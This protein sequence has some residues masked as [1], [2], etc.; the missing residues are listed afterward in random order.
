MGEVRWEILPVLLLVSNGS[1]TLA[2][3]FFVDVCF[4]L[5]ILQV[6]FQVGNFN[7]VNLVRHTHM[8]FWL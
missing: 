8:C 7:G 2:W 1:C 3:A 5:A 6:I 4:E